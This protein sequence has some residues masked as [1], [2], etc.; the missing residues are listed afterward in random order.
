MK[1]KTL[2][3][4]VTMI[5]ALAVLA[6]CAAPAPIATA[7]PVPTATA[8]PTPMPTATPEPAAEASPAPSP[9]A[10]AERTFTLAELAAFNGKNGQPAYV[11]VEGLVYDVT[12]NPGWKDGQHVNYFAGLD[13]T[14]LTKASPHGLAIME[15][16]PVVGKLVSTTGADALLALTL[17]ELAAYNGLE[18]MPAYIAVDGLIYDV[19][20]SAFWKEGMHNG[21]AAGLDLTV[22]IKE[23][24]PHGVGVLEKV[25]V[26]GEIVES[27]DV[28]TSG[29]LLL[30]LEELAAYNGKNGMPAY[31]A[32]NGV[33]YDMTNS[34]LWRNGMHNGNEAGQDLT[35]IIMTKSPHG[36]ST[37]SR[38]PVVGKIKE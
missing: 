36:L 5:L 18:G 10:G 35:E 33:I 20:N 34:A 22:Q 37:L 32:V 9:A 13:L 6:G 23:Q 21:F 25:P 19:T 27:A 1:K 31:V 29:E 24:S 8:S 12:N 38:V 26:V 28:N 3:L 14:E 4:G 2:F 11:A 7:T 30:T 15:D 17:E 16:V